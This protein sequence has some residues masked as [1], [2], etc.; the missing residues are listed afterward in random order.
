MIRSV[1]LISAALWSAS[2]QEFEVASVKPA[3]S[4][5]GRFTMTGG[6]G[7]GDPGRISYTNIPL[8]RVLLDAFD[9]KNYQLNGPDWLDTLRYDIT[10]RVPQGT[11]LDQFHAMMRNLLVSRFRMTLHRESKEMPVYG[12]VEAKS[13]IKIRAVAQPGGPR[14]EE[15]AI[16]KRQEGRDGFPVVDLPTSGLV[17]ET[18]NGAARITAKEVTMARFADFLVRQAGRPVFDETKVPGVYTFELYFTPEG[19]NASSSPEP[20]L[21]AA[22]T[23][24]LGLRLDAS[25]G[26]VE[27]VVI[28]RANKEPAE[29]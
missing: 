16:V 26:P 13:G 4:E 9:L 2:A 22:L 6:P 8:R 1:I 12:L 23:Q 28:D 3:H 27:L 24:Q 20:D 21:F 14:G 7:T 19:P 5:T 18:R 15:M 25:R 10:A 11:S 17:I 29:N